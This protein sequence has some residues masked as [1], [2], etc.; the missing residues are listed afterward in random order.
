VKT[1]A[2]GMGMRGRRA[3]VGRW[4][5]VGGRPG[6]AVGTRPEQT[7]EGGQREQRCRKTHHGRAQLRNPADGPPFPMLIPI[8]EE[9]MEPRLSLVTLGVA[10]LPRA[11]RFYQDVLGWSP[12]FASEDVVFFDLNGTVLSLFPHTE[13]ARDI[14]IAP[15]RTGAY[16]G[17]TLAHNVSGPDLVDQIF[18]QVRE[19]GGT[20]VKPPS[21]A[22]W[23]GYTGYFADP[24]GHHWEVAHNPY[25]T[26][27]PDGR[28]ALQPA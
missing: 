2:D 11:V 20:I 15:E 27:R 25:W 5:T 23:G 17:V 12:A 21:T 28:I 10:D 1:G 16:T 22:F 26:I 8:P 6:R 4:S 24:D 9:A 13:L 18:A 14:G 7:R 19:R 3:V